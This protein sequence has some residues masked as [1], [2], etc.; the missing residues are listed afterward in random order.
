[1]EI[2]SGVRFMKD[3]RS[4]IT[5]MAFC[6]TWKKLSLRQYTSAYKH[7]GEGVSDNAIINPF[8]KRRNHDL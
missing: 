3:A 4:D 1:M 6:L 7:E 2:T 8:S 5:R